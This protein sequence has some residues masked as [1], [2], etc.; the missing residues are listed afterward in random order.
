MQS[1]CFPTL[2]DRSK[3]LLIV[4]ANEVYLTFEVSGT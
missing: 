4:V 3:L 1:V 2:C